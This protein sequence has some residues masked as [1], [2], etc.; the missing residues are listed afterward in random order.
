VG[1]GILGKEGNSA[2]AVSDFSLGQFRF[3]DRLVLHHGR[4]FNYR[5]SYFFVFF[6]LKNMAITVIIY[7]YLFDCAFSGS[8]IFTQLFYL[9]YNSFIGVVMLVNY[10][11]FDQ[12][13]NDDLE[14]AIWNH[15]PRLYSETKRR[16]LFSYWLYFIWSIG[17]IVLAAFIY[18]TIKFS[19]LED[20]CSADG[21]PPDLLTARIANGVALNFVIL[22]LNY[23]DTESHTSFFIN[24]VLILGSILPTA[25]YFIAENYLNILGVQLVYSDNFNLRFWLT[26]FLVV[27]V[28]YASKI[29]FNCLRVEMQPTLV[30][31]YKRAKGEDE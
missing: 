4:W 12:D 29:G 31:F 3:L 10:G 23:M 25:A 21:Q 2:A 5:L 20:A 15:L 19:L 30:D 24:F 7:L 14:P 22:I 17:A 18:Y 27:G 26:V 28:V 9:L 11:L 1:I 8:L 6:G 16:E 13:V